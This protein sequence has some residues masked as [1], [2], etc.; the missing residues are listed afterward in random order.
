MPPPSPQSTRHEEGLLSSITPE[1]S[2][3][4][5]PAPIPLF[6]WVSRAPYSFGTAGSLIDFASMVSE[7]GREETNH[8]D[9]S[10]SSLFSA[11]EDLLEIRNQLESITLDSE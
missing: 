9:V 4:I 5:L 6:E 3:K 8:R 1:E 7:S 2:K 10:R 11:S